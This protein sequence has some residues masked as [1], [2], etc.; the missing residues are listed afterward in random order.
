MLAVVHT[1][2]NFCGAFMLREAARSGGDVQ[3]NVT[4]GLNLIYW[5]SFASVLHSALLYA[6]LYPVM[7][8]AGAAVCRAHAKH[9]DS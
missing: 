3:V 9:A 6:T 7:V 1:V 8:L 5:D 2:I 4:I